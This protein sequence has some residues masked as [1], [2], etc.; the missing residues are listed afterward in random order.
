MFAWRFEVD[1]DRFALP[2]QP[3]VVC[4]PDLRRLQGSRR[5]PKCLVILVVVMVVMVVM[6]DFGLFGSRKIRTGREPLIDCHGGCNC[7]SHHHGA[8]QCRA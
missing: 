4:A 1:R 8:E 5:R 7:Q 6:V 2:A 3:C